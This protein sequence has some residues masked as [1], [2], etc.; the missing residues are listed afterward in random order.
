MSVSAE[1]AKHIPWPGHA[2]ELIGPLRAPPT[3]E[4]SV[5]LVP[6]PQG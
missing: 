3:L 6:K 4:S 2:G 1:Q 5:T